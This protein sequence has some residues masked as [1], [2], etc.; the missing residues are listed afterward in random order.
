MKDQP[1]LKAV[2]KWVTDKRMHKLLGIAETV[3]Q[4][5]VKGLSIDTLLQ[6]GDA[7]IIGLMLLAQIQDETNKKLIFTE[8]TKAALQDAAK[9]WFLQYLKESYGKDSRS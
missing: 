9:T 7:D 2:N 5:P 4:T 3:L 1:D 8:A 6:P